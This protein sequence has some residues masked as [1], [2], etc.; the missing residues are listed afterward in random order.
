MA[1]F[2]FSAQSYDLLLHPCLF[3]GQFLKVKGVQRLKCAVLY[4]V[5]YALPAQPLDLCLQGRYHGIL[6]VDGTS[7]HGFIPL[8]ST[9]YLHA[10]LPALMSVPAPPV[11]YSRMSQHFRYVPAE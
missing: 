10:G 8:F 4:E 6:V 5:I 1:L 3:S 7:R 2:Q 9:Q 11:Q